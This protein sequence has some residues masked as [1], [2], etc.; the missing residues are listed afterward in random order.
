MSEQSF[1]QPLE[2]GISLKDIVDF[3]SESWKAIALSGIVGGLLATGYAF[4]TPPK[5][6]ATAYIQVAKVAG[7]DLE[8]PS[9]LVEK[10]KMPMYYSMTSYSACNLMDSIESGEVIAKNIKPTLPKGSNIINFSYINSDTEDVK[11]CL[12]GIFS[13]I[14]SKQNLSAKPIIEMKK[15]ELKVLKQKL[16]D[17]EKFMRISP[18]KISSLDS[19]DSNHSLSSFFLAISLIKENQIID[20][21]KEI[22]ELE[23]ALVEPQTREVSLIAPIY[24]SN[25]K[26]SPNRFLISISGLMT[27]L[28]IGLLFMICRRSWLALKISN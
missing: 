11:K 6:Q 16:D 2:D 28:L 20:L 27:G 5:Y 17:V 23:A 12:E 9:I 3:L 26:V 13:E 25:Q 7:A 1:N 8:A 19:F 22:K 18:K 15:N 21:R 14:R 4:I 24:V 10:L